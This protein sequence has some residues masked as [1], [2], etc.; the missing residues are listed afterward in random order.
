MSKP[1]APAS[2]PSFSASIAEPMLR[3]GYEYWRGKRAGRSMPRRS[4]IDPAE[5][6]ALLPH[7]MITEVLDEGRRFR[8]R[9]AGSAVTEA[10]GDSLT[11]K[12][13]D[14]ILKGEYGDFI[15]QIYRTI[16]TDPR[17]LFCESRY[18][19]STRAGI[20]TKRL[21]MPLSNDD[22]VVNQI[23][24]VQTFDYAGP[25]RNVV[26]VDNMDDFVGANIAIPDT[27]GDGR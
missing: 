9:L 5:I 19:G 10:F 4:D 12:Y 18:T 1:T 8:Y 27:A 22:R 11:G 2:L 20:T 24:I 7:L 26:I 3:A 23:L 14:E 16:C 13:V 6:P 17:C 15:L 21:F 25:E